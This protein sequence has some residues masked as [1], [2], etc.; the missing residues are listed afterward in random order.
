[1]AYGLEL[2]AGIS[3]EPVSP[4]VEENGRHKRQI[5][6]DSTGDPADAHNCLPCEASPTVP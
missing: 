1:M 2:G 6:H 5:I 4:G 3:L